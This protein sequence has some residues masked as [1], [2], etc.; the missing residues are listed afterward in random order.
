[1]SVT[2]LLEVQS[3][4]EKL[5]EL[6]S[7]FKNTLP[8]TRAYEGCQ[9]VEVIENQDDS[10]NLILIQRWDSRQHYEKY[11]GWRTKTGAVKALGA[12]L[13]QPPSVRYF[14]GIKA[15]KE[16]QALN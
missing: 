15:L 1:M 7:T 2:V 5:A 8:D 6:K 14:D 16:F 9:G 3:K 4:L 13:A 11:L 10:C 12:M